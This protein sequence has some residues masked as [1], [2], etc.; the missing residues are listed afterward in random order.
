MV[1][2]AFQ[3]L[4]IL[5]HFRCCMVLPTWILSSLNASKNESQRTN[6]TQYDSCSDYRYLR[7]PMKFPVGLGVFRYVSLSS[8]KSDQ[9]T[10]M[11]RHAALVAE[12]VALEMAAAG[13]WD[14]FCWMDCCWIAAGLLDDCCWIRFLS[15][16]NNYPGYWYIYIYIHMHLHMILYYICKVLTCS[17]ALEGLLLDW[18]KTSHRAGEQQ[19]FGS[20]REAT[21]CARWKNL[22]EIIYWL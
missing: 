7:S 13:Q 11:S 4:M 18:W 21:W 2:S 5:G 14:R 1:K 10:A 19:F 15:L 20:A 22:P 9:V 8:P 6:S 17:D 12:S 3:I 16:L